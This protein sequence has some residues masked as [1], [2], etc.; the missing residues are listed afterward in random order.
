MLMRKSLTYVCAHIMVKVDSFSIRR[1][2]ND[3]TSTLDREFDGYVMM[4]K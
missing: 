4:W 1:L 2:F 3:V